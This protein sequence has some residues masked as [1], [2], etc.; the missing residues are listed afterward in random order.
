MAKKSELMKQDQGQEQVQEQAQASPSKTKEVQV[1]EVPNS[2]SWLTDYDL[3][4][5]M[6]DLRAK[7][8]LKSV[9]IGHRGVVIEIFK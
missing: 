2:S 7:Y 9:Y 3:G 4:A 1:L 6:D 8:T 5:K